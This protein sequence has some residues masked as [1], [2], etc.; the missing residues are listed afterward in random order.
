MP[1][2]FESLYETWHRPMLYVAEQILKDH[3]LAEDAVQ[4]ALFRISRQKHCLPSEDKALRAYVLTSA[5]HAALDLLPNL[6]KEADI[7]SIVVADPRD[8]FSE[9]AA[10]Q[11]YERILKAI[12]DLPEMYRDV[13]MLRYVQELKVGQIARL[14]G[15]TKSTVSK[16]LQRAKALLEKHYLKEE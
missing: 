15:K 11:D 2:T 12:S 1:R 10:S 9:V 6:P 7:D 8:I 16:Q 5:K 3:H 13:L 4:N 14:L